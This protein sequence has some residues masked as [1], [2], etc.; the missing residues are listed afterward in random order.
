MLLRVFISH[1]NVRRVQL[2]QMPESVGQLKAVLTEKLQLQGD[3][4]V[5]FEDLEF[6]NALTSLS[7]ISEL[8]PEKAVLKL[9]WDNDS[10]VL[11]ISDAGSMSSL[12]TATVSS[13]SSHSP[14]ATIQSF[15]RSTSQWPSTINI[16]DF[17]YDV[18]L[19]LAKGNKVFEQTKRS[20]NVSREMKIEI[21]DKIA[22]A[23]FTFKAYPESN[24]IDSI[25]SA[26][27]VKHPCLTEPGSGKG[28]EG[29]KM[30]IKY[31]IGNYRSKLRAAGCKEVN[32]NRKREKE[33]DEDETRQSIKRSKRG[34]VNYMPDHPEGQNDDTLEDERLFL[35]EEMK[36]KKGASAI[37]SEKM[38]LTFSLRR[39]EIVA[40][41]PI[42]SEVLKRW[43]ALFSTQEIRRV[44][45]P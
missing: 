8:P 5:Q 12:D 24:E 35:V 20:L 40:M 25:A 10:S 23:I 33:L 29:W 34:E 6:D 9:F 37:C 14:S 27:I 36:K 30:S 22:Q 45:P 28:Y 3:F 32:I 39:R 2:P 16:P 15:L 31:K 4:L 17:S 1:L 43:P 38:H 19:R 13:A 11:D 18:E 41:A 44:D 7:D 42:V 21:L 26:L